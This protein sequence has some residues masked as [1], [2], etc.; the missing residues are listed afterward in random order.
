MSMS[1][2]AGTPQNLHFIHI[3]PVCFGGKYTKKMPIY[4]TKGSENVR[5][6]IVTQG[7]HMR[8]VPNSRHNRW[9]LFRHP[10]RKFS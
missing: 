3:G 8:I 5:Y 7:A 10:K 9:E 4:K 1:M 6:F 2:S